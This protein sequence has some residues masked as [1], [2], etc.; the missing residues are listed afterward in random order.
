MAGILTFKEKNMMFSV[1]ILGTRI[2]IS[3]SFSLS[4]NNTT[5]HLKYIL[6]NS[7]SIHFCFS[8]KF[9]KYFPVNLNST[10]V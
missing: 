1:F 3:F 10:D 8:G 2:S 6:D 7:A 9:S 4:D 5:A